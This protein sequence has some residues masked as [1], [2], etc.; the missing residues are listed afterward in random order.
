MIEKIERSIPE[1]WAV[2]MKQT[3]NREMLDKFG[4]PSMNGLARATGL[5]PVTVRRLIHGEYTKTGPEPQVIHKVAQA[6]GKKPSVIAKWAGL[7]GTISEKLYEL[8]PEAAYLTPRQQ[9]MVDSFIR[10]LT[11]HAR[12]TA[13]ASD[14][15][16][17][18]LVLR[19]PTRVG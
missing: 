17:E 8:P 4:E 15:A 1:K 7:N 13:A 11:E 5:A 6:L 3:G 9:K 19:R 16:A 18:S 10:D 14:E 12:M 2:A